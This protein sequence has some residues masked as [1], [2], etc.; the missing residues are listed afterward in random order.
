MYSGSL[1]QSLIELLEFVN[2]SDEDIGI[3]P[4]NLGVCDVNQVLIDV[5]NLRGSLKFAI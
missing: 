5:I 4:V 1:L 3:A 2:L